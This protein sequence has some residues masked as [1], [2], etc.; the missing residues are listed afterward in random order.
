MT[1]HERSRLV[2]RDEPH[3]GRDVEHPRKTER[4]GG[5][6][7]FGSLKEVSMN[8]LRLTSAAAIAAASLGIA[9]AASAGP[10]VNLSAGT[11]DV[12]TQ[13]DA[14]KPV[15]HY[16]YGYRPYYYGYYP[17]YY[18]RP[19][20]YYQPYYYYGTPYYYGPSFN[21]GIQIR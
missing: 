12:A 10:A 4:G 13:S 6:P 20:R 1:A 18:Y 15:Y 9:G 8:I 17:R 21:F 11:Q 19:Y 5:A 7:S 3:S 16:S 14:V 2:Q